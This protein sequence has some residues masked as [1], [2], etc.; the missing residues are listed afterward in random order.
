MNNLKSLAEKLSLNILHCPGDMRYQ[1]WLM[2]IT[3]WTVPA[4]FCCPDICKCSIKSASVKA[5]VDCHK[6]GLRVFPSNLP[7]DA[8]ILKLGECVEQK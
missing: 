8:W 4:A 5:E 7:S 3:L 2:V 6:R 1:K